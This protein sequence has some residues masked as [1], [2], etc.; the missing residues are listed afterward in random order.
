MAV[1]SN[2]VFIFVSCNLREFIICV[3]RQELPK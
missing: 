1:K 3:E 2:E